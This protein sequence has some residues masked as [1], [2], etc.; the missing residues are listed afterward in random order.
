MEKKSEPEQRV[1]DN[2]KPSKSA[3]AAELMQQ[4]TGGLVGFTLNSGHLLTP[5]GSGML[6]DDAFDAGLDG[7]LKMSLRKLS[8]KD[9]LTKCKALDELK[10][11]I[12]IKTTDECVTILPYWSKSFTKLALVHY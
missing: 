7:D 9:P 4:V 12:D 2:A 11:L 8:K 3:R 10:A 6:L 1:K 5:M